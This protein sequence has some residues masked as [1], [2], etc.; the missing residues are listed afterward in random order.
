MWAICCWWLKVSLLFDRL[1]DLVKLGPLRRMKHELATR[2]RE[3]RGGR[4]GD[5]GLRPRGARHAAD[6]D[7]SVLGGSPPVPD[8]GG[9]T[10]VSLNIRSVSVDADVMTV[11]LLDGAQQVTTTFEGA[12]SSTLS[13]GTGGHAAVAFQVTPRSADDAAKPLNRPPLNF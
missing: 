5:N 8:V 2:D 4:G 12:I 3:V 10:G 1:V 13:V 7:T 9:G 11:V 6:D